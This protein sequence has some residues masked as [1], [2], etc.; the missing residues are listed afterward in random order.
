MSSLLRLGFTGTQEGMAQAQ[1]KELLAHLK[2]W[3]TLHSELEIHHGDCIG[4]DAE[5]HALCTS[6]W[7]ANRISVVV[8]PPT[9]EGKRAFCQFENQ[10]VLPAKPYLER[11]RA[12]V[13]SVE[14]MVAGPK[15]LEEELR[16][17]TWATIR[18]AKK[19]LTPLIILKP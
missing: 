6:I 9:N 1:Q 4:A 5:F 18:Y 13:D 3:L 10:V 12:I 17:G 11:N 16:S 7:P 14:G 19:Q 2:R 15:T 8:H